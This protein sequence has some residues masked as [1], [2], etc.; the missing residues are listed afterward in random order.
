MDEREIGKVG[1]YEQIFTMIDGEVAR[2]IGIMLF[3]ADSEAKDE[4]CKECMG[5]IPGLAVQHS[6]D[7][8]G[9]ILKEVEKAFGEGRCVLVVMDGYASGDHTQRHKTVVAL[10]NLGAKSVLGIYVKIAAPQPEIGK[11][12]SRSDAVRSAA[13]VEKL[14]QHPPTPD[15]LEYLAIVEKEPQ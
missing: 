6:N 7:N 3:G 14:E 12:F 15:G 2:P 10:R 11:G 9:T 4:I 13:Q 1:T 5:K 8:S